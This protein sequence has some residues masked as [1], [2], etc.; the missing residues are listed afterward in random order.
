MRV[1]QARSALLGTL[2]IL[3]L[4]QQFGHARNLIICSRVIQAF[5]TFVFGKIML[6]CLPAAGFAKI[7]KYT[8]DGFLG[9]FGPSE[10]PIPR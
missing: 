9:V 2:L 10:R 7:K 8:Y 4:L 5:I 3:E 6:V 1:F